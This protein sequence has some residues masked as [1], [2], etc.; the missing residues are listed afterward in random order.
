M[1]DREWEREDEWE[2]QGEQV[3]L[4]E[5][6][7]EMRREMRVNEYKIQQGAYEHIWA[8]YFQAITMEAHQHFLNI[9]I[10]H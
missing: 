8:W 10:M 4:R 2:G 1:G 7:N 5:K 3:L 6:E 9:L